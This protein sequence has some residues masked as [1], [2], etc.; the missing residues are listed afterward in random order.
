MIYKK[1][2]QEEDFEKLDRAYS[3]DPGSARVG[4]GLGLAKPGQMVQP[5]EKAALS[6]NEGEIS[7][8]VKSEFG[9]HIIQ[10]LEKN[11]GGFKS[12][13]ILIRAQ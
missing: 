7:K 10:L 5:Y 2:M 13:H 11:P 3:N 8:P 1:L 9:Y 6:L 12:R 4:G